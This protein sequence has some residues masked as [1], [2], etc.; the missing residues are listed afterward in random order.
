GDMPVFLQHLHS[1]SEQWVEIFWVIDQFS[2]HPLRIGF[3]RGRSYDSS[4]FAPKAREIFLERSPLDREIHCGAEVVD[5]V[6]MVP[7]R[8]EEIDLFLRYIHYSIY[9]YPQIAC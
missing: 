4:P 2:G 3:P 9:L 5:H 6:V 8:V 7:K 1:K